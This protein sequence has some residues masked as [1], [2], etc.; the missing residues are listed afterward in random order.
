MFQGVSNSDSG[1]VHWFIYE[2]GMLWR[3]VCGRIEELMFECGSSDSSREY[4]GNG[5]VEEE[6]FF[7]FY[8]IEVHLRDKRRRLI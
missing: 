8:L 5:R 3:L 7:E 1:S 4:G 2:N 6:C